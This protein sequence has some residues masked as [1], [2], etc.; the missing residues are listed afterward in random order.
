MQFD[1][2]FPTYLVKDINLR[3]AE[4][5]LPLCNRYTDETKTNC[6]HIE[7]FPS[8]LY[9]RDLERKVMDEPE[10]KEAFDIIIESYLKPFLN[11]RGINLPQPLKPF[12]FFS[13]MKKHA[14]LRKHCHLDSLFAGIIYLEVGKEVPPLILYDPKPMRSFINWPLLPNNTKDTPLLVIPP[15]QGLVLLWDSYLEH[16]VPQKLN[17]EPRKTFVFNL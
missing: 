7:N 2:I 8:T 16:E 3:L 15:Q 13:S 9:D 10:V 1:E 17:D 6:L 5:L 14:Y 11:H 4:K 12:G